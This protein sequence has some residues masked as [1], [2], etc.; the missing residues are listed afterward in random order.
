MKK[1]HFLFVLAGLF[2]LLTVFSFNRTNANNDENGLL[3]SITIMT[4]ANAVVN[5]D[6]PTGCK[7]SGE[8]C[9]CYKF[10]P[11]LYGNI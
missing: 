5:P 4:K 11:F 1:K 6:C 8:G 9:Y 2:V 7:E 3:K 10:Y